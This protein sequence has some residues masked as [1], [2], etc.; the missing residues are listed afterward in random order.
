[1]LVYLLT[2][3]AVPLLCRGGHP[4]P[5]G[6]PARSRGSPA[7]GRTRTPRRDLPST[8][9]RARASGATSTTILAHSL[10]V[11]NLQVSVAS[12][13]LESH[14]PTGRRRRWPRRGRPAPKRSRRTAGH[15]G[16]AAWRRIQQ[17]A[18]A[19]SDG[20]AGVG[21][22]GAEHRRA[23]T[24]TSDLDTTPDVSSAV[25]IVAYRVVQEGLTNVVKHA[26]GAASKSRW[27]CA[28]VG[29]SSRSPTRRRLGR[30]RPPR[31]GSAWKACGNGWR[32]SAVSS[33]LARTPT[34]ASSCRPTCRRTR[35]TTTRTWRIATIRVVIADDQPLL[36]SALANLFGA[37]DDLEVVGEAGTGRGRSTSCG[38]RGPTWW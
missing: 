8:G 28:T 10:T 26:G 22:A 37:G 27:R 6:L 11:V 24:L 14:P 16:A 29:S 4:E 1:M 7:T 3:V 33:P 18:G 17:R 9:R 5:A 15:A 25:G 30:S 12:T 38:A 36:R 23:V 31:P 21:G 32:P 2:A 35:T 20:L 19:G 34:A 13:L